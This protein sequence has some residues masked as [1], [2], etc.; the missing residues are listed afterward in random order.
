MNTVR[1]GPDR[2][3]RL[4]T[5]AVVPR[6]R[7]RRRSHRRRF[8][9][10]RLVGP[11][12]GVVTLGAVTATAVMPGASAA[13]RRVADVFAPPPPPPFSATPYVVGLD[14]TASPRP[15][16]PPVDVT[17]PMSVPLPLASASD[18]PR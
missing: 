15:V 1:R 9:P 14:P 6:G 8:Q 7:H 16:I 2:C 13:P 18:I 17:G 12:I 5:L 3:L 4:P 11:G 10:S